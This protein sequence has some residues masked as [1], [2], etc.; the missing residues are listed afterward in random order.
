MNRTADCESSCR[1]VH[2]VRLLW[3]RRVRRLEAAKRVNHFLP[4]RVPGRKYF[5]RSVRRSGLAA[6]REAECLSKKCLHFFDIRTADCESSCRPVHLVRY[7]VSL[8]RLWYDTLKS[9]W[10]GSAA[11]PAAT[12][13]DRAAGTAETL[14]AGPRT[15]PARDPADTAGA[16]AAP[17]PGGP[18]R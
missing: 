2:V 8:A 10:T 1:P 17:E 5:S 7:L 3:P 15:S 11:P 14:W 9:R 13:R 4:G 16:S 6:R 18:G 12:D